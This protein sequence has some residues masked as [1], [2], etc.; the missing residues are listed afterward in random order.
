M[1]FLQQTLA[2]LFLEG[3]S[4][5]FFNRSDLM[6]VNTYDFNVY[7]FNEYFNSIITTQAICDL[8]QVESARV[9]CDY[10][11]Y[12]IEMSRVIF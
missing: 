11:Y 9:I 1:I 3:F 5:F 10:D 7:N 8:D 12:N 4:D 6:R 2:F